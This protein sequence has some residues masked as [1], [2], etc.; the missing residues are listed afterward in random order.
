MEQ[1]KYD[2]SAFFESDSRMP[3]SQEGLSAAGGRPVLRVMLPG[4]KGK[5][6]PDLGVVWMA[7]PLY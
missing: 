6:V 3:R 1:N 7:L 2:D 5:R 4:L